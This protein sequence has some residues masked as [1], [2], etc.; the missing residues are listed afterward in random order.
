MKTIAISIDEATLR[1]IDR[2][3]SGL[4]AVS[5]SAKR[6][7]T[8]GANRSKVIRTALREYV[9]RQQR[10][11]REEREREV[12]ARHRRTLLR[13]ARALVEEQAEP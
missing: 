1:D 5:S 9:A 11:Q 6:L 2:I 13:Q 12:Y 3:A 10:A 4:R 7:G 8:R